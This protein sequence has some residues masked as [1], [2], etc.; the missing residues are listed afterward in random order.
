[1]RFFMFKSL[2][3]ERLGTAMRSW[4][5]SVVVAVCLNPCVSGLHTWIP[6]NTTWKVVP[7]GRVHLWGSKD[8]FLEAV[9]CFLRKGTQVTRFKQWSPVSLSRLPNLITLTCCVYLQC[10]LGDF[11]GGKQCCK[12]EPLDVK[13]NHYFHYKTIH[14]HCRKISKK[15]LSYFK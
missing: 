1:M 4:S 15:A 3:W 9:P 14:T 10:A 6:H 7:C 13:N 11:S 12:N 2:P 8:S 5:P